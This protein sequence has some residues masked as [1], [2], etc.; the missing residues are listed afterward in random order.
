MQATW[1]VSRNQTWYKY[2]QAIC[3]VII[4]LL[5]EQRK[6]HG[7]GSGL[8][9]QWM[10]SAKR[11]LLHVL[12]ILII[13]WSVKTNWLS[14]IYHI[15]KFIQVKSSKRKNILIVQNLIKLFRLKIRKNRNEN[16]RITKYQRLQG[17]GNSTGRFLGANCIST[18]DLHAKSQPNNIGLPVLSVCFVEKAW[19]VIE[20]ILR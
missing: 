12:H 11:R 16:R 13:F 9:L 6:R 7:T 1:I 3:D 10:L 19:M 4:L 15:V 18:Q 20:D 8:C 2:R 17:S 14:L 5:I